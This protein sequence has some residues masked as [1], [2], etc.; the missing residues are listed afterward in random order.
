MSSHLVRR[1]LRRLIASL[2]IHKSTEGLARWKESYETSKVG[3]DSCFSYT[4]DGTVERFRELSDSA[5][6]SGTPSLSESSIARVRVEPIKPC[7][8]M[9]ASM[10]GVKLGPM[11]SAVSCPRCV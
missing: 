1:G 10:L 4:L 5:V 6:V 8:F 11:E 7:R 3:L 2:S 9:L